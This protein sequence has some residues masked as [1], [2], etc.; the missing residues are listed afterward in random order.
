[1]KRQYPYLLDPYYQDLNTT[2]QKQDFLSK[3]DDYV[4]QKQYIRITLLSWSELPIKEIQGELSS[5]SITKD[6]SSSIRRTCNLAA[7]VDAGS[8]DVEDL[9]LDFSI[10]KKVFVEIGV[11]NRTD[12]YKKYPIFWFPQGVFYISSASIT[13]STSS[14]VNISLSLKDKMCGLN[15]ITG[16]TFPIATIID[17]AETQ[18]ASGAYTSTKVNIYSIIQELV[19]HFG[20]EELDNIIIEDVP[21]RIKRV[22]KWNGDTPLYLSPVNNDG[23]I[24]YNISTASDYQD[25]ISDSTKPAVLKYSYGDEIGYVWEDFVYTKELTAN[26]GESVT[27]VLDKLVSYLGNYEYFFDE[28]GIFH[29]REKKNYLNTTLGSIALTDMS[30]NDYL[31]DTTVGKS[32]YSFSDNCNIASM[33]QNP[34][35]ENIKNDFVVTGTGT[36]ASTNATYSVI[37]HLAIDKKP[38]NLNTYYGLLIYKEPSTGLVKIG[39]PTIIG[40]GNDLPEIGDNNLIYAQFRKDTEFNIVSLEAYDTNEEERNSLQSQEEEI[41]LQID[42]LNKQKSLNDAKQTL[43]NVAIYYIA[44]NFGKS[45][46]SDSFKSILDSMLQNQELDSNRLIELLGLLDEKEE[47]A[48]DKAKAK[49]ENLLSNLSYLSKLSEEDKEDF[50]KIKEDLVSDIET[51]NLEDISDEN[52]AKKILEEVTLNTRMNNIEIENSIIQVNIENL[53]KSI[54]NIE[55]QLEKL[56]PSFDVNISTVESATISNISADK[57]EFNYLATNY[58]S[59]SDKIISSSE[60]SESVDWDYKEVKTSYENITAATIDSNDNVY[61]NY[62]ETIKKESSDYTKMKTTLSSNSFNQYY[63][64]NTKVYYYIK[65]DSK[66]NSCYTLTIDDNNNKVFNQITDEQVNSEDIVAYARKELTLTEYYAVKQNPSIYDFHFYYWDDDNLFYGEFL[67][68]EDDDEKIITYYLPT[69]FPQDENKDTDEG[70]IMK[71][72]YGEGTRYPTAY[73]FA[74]WAL[75]LSSTYNYIE[76]GYTPTDWRTEMYLQ[77]MINKN[78]GTSAN[79]IL[80]DDNTQYFSIASQLDKYNNGTLNAS[81]EEYEWISS[82]G[83]NMSQQVV[84][85]DYYFPELEAFWPQVYDLKNGGFYSGVETGGCYYLDFIDPTDS[86]AN[87]IAEYCISNIG[88]RS[89][90]VSSKDVNCLFEPEI[91]EVCYI[92][93][94]GGASGRTKDEVQADVDECIDQNIAYCQLDANTYSNLVT[95]GSHNAAYEE[96]KTNLME[97]T[98]FKKTISMTTLPVF[99]LDVNSRITVNDKT[100]N[101]YGDFTVSNLSIPLGAGSMMSVSASACTEKP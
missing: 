59:D 53:N 21:Q 64:L 55:E 50:I 93:A 81:D 49:L 26:A 77:G 7:T 17:E 27:S 35:Y 57:K 60:V 100:T 8:Y 90:V 48:K 25:Y 71:S 56:N 65:T 98:T 39:F 33:T 23:D 75:S 76:T 101:T 69:T 2:Q 38:I 6:G 68:D 11:E 19:N 13:S 15:G 94:A 29:F 47:D 36:S 95:G 41:Q 45:N 73:S 92:L 58:L 97:Y 40:M 51:L 89:K 62:I 79:Y 72:F 74:K 4:N 66:N 3:L 16:G 86:N 78:S 18:S 44:A 87:Q 88:R 24:T 37:Y 84:D 52:Q 67:D 83:L 9:N 30:E 1:M 96:I 32:T 28:Y 46:L 91:P 85:I 22:V 14:V 5:G 43:Y 10:N 63:Q 42:D 12:K 20:N 80:T 70:T 31:V 82:L 61:D 54:E 99:Y 34:Q